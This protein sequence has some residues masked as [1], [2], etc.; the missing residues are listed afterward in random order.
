M[1]NEDTFDYDTPIY[2]INAARRRPA[3]PRQP[4]RLPFQSWQSL[5]NEDRQRWDQFSDQTKALLLGHTKT[6]DSPASSSGT[7]PTTHPGSRS[8]SV[9]FQ[10]IT[11]DDL[12]LA[13]S[14][15]TT[16]TGRDQQLDDS[17]DHSCT[18]DGVC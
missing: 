1:N 10:D 8:L 16:S 7:R 3:R 9:Q 12:S 13:V 17:G 11:P 14:R 5:S 15:L 6:P 2:E 4:G 18:I